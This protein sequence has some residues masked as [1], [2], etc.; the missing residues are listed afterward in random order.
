MAMS[1]LQVIEVKNFLNLD[2]QLLALMQVILHLYVAKSITSDD[3]SEVE[4][5]V[6]LAKGAKVMLTMNW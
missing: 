5:T 4:P 2:S 1:N 3:M 6:F